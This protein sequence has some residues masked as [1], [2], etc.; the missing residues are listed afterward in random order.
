MK[1]ILAVATV[2]SSLVATSAFA[3]DAV[4]PAASPVAS[5][6]ASPAAV[7]VELPKTE[8]PKTEAPKNEA[9]KTEVKIPTKSTKFSGSIVSVDAT[10][11]KIVVKVGKKDE[12]FALG[13][14]KLMKSN[15]EIQLADLKMGDRVSGSAMSKDGTETLESLSVV[16]GSKTLV[17]P[18]K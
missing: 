6:A 14:V 10:G 11:K 4:Q 15:K 5:P 7:K 1:K 9:P 3:A 16:G 8:A 17:V 2:L 12:T 18:K 13:D